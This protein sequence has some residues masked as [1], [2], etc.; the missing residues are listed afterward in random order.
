M[1]AA[2]FLSKLYILH[3]KAEKVQ[4]VDR[5]P[6]VFT[7]TPERVNVKCKHLVFKKTD[8]KSHF[9]YQH[10]ACSEPSNLAQYTKDYCEIISCRGCKFEKPNA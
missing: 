5:V 6:F 1:S 7:I 8:F 2:S 3:K 9:G 10:P 4:S